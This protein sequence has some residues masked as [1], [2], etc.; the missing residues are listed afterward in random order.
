MASCLISGGVATIPCRDNLPGISKFYIANFSEVTQV[1][2]E[3][4]LV[5]GITM[6]GGTSF[7]EFNVN[8]ESSSYSVAPTTDVANGVTNWTVTITMVMGKMDS[9]KANLLRVLAAGNFVVIALDRNGKYWLFGAADDGDTGVYVNGG[10]I[11]SGTSGTDLS[12]ASIQIGGSTFGPPPEV[13]AS[14]VAGII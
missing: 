6:S 9:S 1:D 2:V 3:D 13:E 5:T 7:Y 12:G 14:V 10:E 4:S 11:A 8:P